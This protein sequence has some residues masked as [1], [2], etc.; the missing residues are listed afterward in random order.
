MSETFVATTAGQRYVCYVT[1]NGINRHYLGCHHDTPRLAIDHVPASRSAVEPLAHPSGGQPRQSEAL[2]H[3]TV[4]TSTPSLWPVT[5]G[6]G[7]K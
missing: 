3:P 1:T 2:D 4:G 7:A 6:G 5:Q